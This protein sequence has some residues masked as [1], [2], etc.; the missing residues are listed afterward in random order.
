MTIYG[1]LLLFQNHCIPLPIILARLLQLIAEGVVHSIRPVVSAL[2]HSSGPR[3]IT[4]VKQVWAI[5][6]ARA[7]PLGPP[8]QLS[9]PMDYL[10]T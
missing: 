7:L 4:G 9:D 1:I 2:I 5:V 10:D 8:T 3:Q 6:M